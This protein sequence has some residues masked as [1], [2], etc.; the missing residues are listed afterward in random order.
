MNCVKCGKPL[1][2]DLAAKY[3]IMGEIFGEAMTPEDI[4]CYDCHVPHVCP[5]DCESCRWE[6][7]NLSE[8]S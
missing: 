8:S 6:R 3:K 1:D 2:D 5:L 7:E 4:T